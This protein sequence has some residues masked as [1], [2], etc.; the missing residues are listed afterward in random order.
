MEESHAQTMS[1][2]ED[3]AGGKGDDR[4]EEMTSSTTEDEKTQQ[5]R[6]H[7]WKEDVATQPSNGK[8]EDVSQAFDGFESAED[9]TS[10]GGGDRNVK[11][12]DE[13]DDDDEGET[14]TTVKE[15]EDRDTLSEEKEEEVREEEEELG[16]EEDDTPRDMTFP[17]SS[18]QTS[19]DPSESESDS[20]RAQTPENVV[21]PRNDAELKVSTSNDEG[22]RAVEKSI[23]DE[24]KTVDGTTEDVPDTKKVVEFE[25]GE[26]VV[27]ETGEEEEEK[28]IVI[29]TKEGD[30]IVI[31]SDDKEATT[32]NTTTVADLG[33]GN[34]LETEATTNDAESQGVDVET[35]SD[36]ETATSN[37]T[38]VAGTSNTDDAEKSKI[39]AMKRMK[40]EFTNF[41]ETFLKKDKKAREDVI[42]D[43]KSKTK[44][45]LEAFNKTKDDPTAPKPD[46]TE[47]DRI[48]LGLL[49]MAQS[50]HWKLEMQHVCKDMTPAQKRAYF[51]KI[52]ETVRGLEAKARAVDPEAR[53]DIAKNF[54]DEE[55]QAVEFYRIML[56]ETKANTIPMEIVVPQNFRGNKLT[57]IIPA[58]LM[59]RGMGAQQILAMKSNPQARYFLDVTIP[60][61]IKPGMT[62]Q[63]GVDRRELIVT[64]VPDN[65]EPGKPIVIELAKMKF[66]MYI[67]PQCKPG[68]RWCILQDDLIRAIQSLKKSDIQTKPKTPQTTAG[69]VDAN[70]ASTSSPAVKKPDAVTLT[71]S[72]DDE[73]LDGEEEDDKETTASQTAAQSVVPK[74]TTKTTPRTPSRPREKIK[75]VGS[76]K[77]DALIISGLVGLAVAGYF[78]WTTLSGGSRAARRRRR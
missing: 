49:N 63:F 69:A 60:P 2:N 45:L 73:P 74:T 57:T 16:D 43:L 28:K 62:Y 22:N 66:Q 21:F 25:D 48:H 59:M 3:R 27:V 29:E 75:T 35:K 42:S 19:P 7:D 36:V 8:S 77:E 40:E 18:A 6:P 26:E 17:S 12:N 33:T 38:T 54:S 56:E 76:W 15:S 78:L 55:R 24:K 67:S 47:Q 23:D 5:Q 20:S 37:G 14:K 72:I 71:D 46:V 39:A 65:Y 4:N 53:A 50:M 51:Q 34:T 52:G 10:K 41:R 31:V 58:Q 11:R 44:A 13:R 32:S 64:T 68:D 9:E 1:E 30:N 61:H 70:T